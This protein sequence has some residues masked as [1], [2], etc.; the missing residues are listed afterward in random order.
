[1]SPIPEQT[2]TL[3]LHQLQTLNL[4]MQRVQTKLAEEALA[5]QTSN[6]E[7]SEIKHTLDRLEST[8][9]KLGAPVD[10]AI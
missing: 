4:E 7:N 2:E 5:R 6:R 8:L 1:M 3:I 10:T 9:F